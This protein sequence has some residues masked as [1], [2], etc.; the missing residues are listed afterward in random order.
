[1][2]N[3]KETFFVWGNTPTLYEASSKR[4]PT[5]VFF[6]IPL[7]Y[8]PTTQTLTQRT[9]RQLERTQPELLVINMFDN[10]APASHPIVQWFNSNYTTHPLLESGDPKFRLYYRKG[11]ALSSRLEEALPMS[12]LHPTKIDRD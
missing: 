5:G 11:G 12:S 2:L 4:P 9:L 7:L 1:M 10:P 8:G 6:V 3:P